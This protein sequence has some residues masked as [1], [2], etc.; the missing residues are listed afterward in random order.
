MQ[1][2]VPFGKLD[3]ASRDAVLK[4][5]PD[6]TLDWYECTIWRYLPYCGWQYI[7]VSCEV[8]A[9]PGFASQV[10]A[11]VAARGAAYGSPADNH[12]TTANM[13]SEWLSRRLK[14]PVKL[15]AEDVCMLNIIQKVSRLA[16]GTKDDSYLDIAGYV[17]NVAMLREDQR[18]K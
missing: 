5:C 17:E 1:D 2:Y 10:L 13:V 16:S 18:N 11:T 12:Q 4:R 14:T 3:A 6:K 15:S 8:S 9:K 7:I